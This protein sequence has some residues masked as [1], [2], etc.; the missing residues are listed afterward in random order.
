[1]AVTVHLSGHLKAFSNG[2]VEVD[3]PGEFATVSD[4]L[5]ALWKVQAGLR[6]R[7]LNEQGEIRQHVNI[8][9]GNVDI[10]RK[11]GLA[12]VLNAD[13]IHIFNAV[14]GG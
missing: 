6:D 13:S 5:A 12:T 4:A 10:K 1:M 3:L 9:A 11:K 14:S 2:Q 7:V 8:F